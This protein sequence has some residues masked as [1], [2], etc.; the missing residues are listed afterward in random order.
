MTPPRAAHPAAL[1]IALLA[2]VSACAAPKSEPPP[3]TD[4]SPPTP[5]PTPGAASE[6]A[7]ADTAPLPE[8]SADDSHIAPIAPVFNEGLEVAW[9]ITRDTDNAVG[10]SLARFANR[11]SPLPGG[12]VGTWERAGFRVLALDESDVHDLLEALPP[13]GLVRRDWIGRKVRWTECFRPPAEAKAE[14]HRIVG[15]PHEVNPGRLRFITRAWSAP[16]GAASGDEGAVLRV[17]LA[18]Q[19]YTPTRTVP[20]VTLDE[21]RLPL[22]QH[23][24]T[25]LADVTAE[26]TLHASQVLLITGEAPGVVWSTPD[27]T[28]PKD[29]EPPAAVPADQFDPGVAAPKDDN[30]NA[31][32]GP[33]VEQ[34]VT[35]GQAMLTAETSAIYPT[36]TRTIIL[37][38]PRVP[39]HFSLLPE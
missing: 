6:P 37:L 9:W 2:L 26:L 5:A 17:D 39:T 28:Q 24:G 14:P 34:P 33:H 11:P 15:L 38:I 27:K 4:A 1:A 16:A 36:P 35:P 13:V 8:R 22:A 7:P 21:P 3:A 31:A 19:L 10:S 12:V 32:F 30:P 18:L 20:R 23:E 25:I 29:D